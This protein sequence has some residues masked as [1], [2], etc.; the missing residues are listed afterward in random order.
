MTLPIPRPVSPVSEAVL[1]YGGHHQGHVRKDDQDYVLWWGLKDLDTSPLPDES[2]DPRAGSRFF[3]PARFFAVADGMGGL[4]E[5]ATA[6]RQAAHAALDTFRRL[7]LEFNAKAGEW[8]GG[9]GGDPGAVRDWADPSIPHLAGSQM[10]D[11]LQVVM[12]SVEA[13]NAP[14]WQESAGKSGCTLLVAAVCDYRVFIAYVGDCRAYLI[15]PQGPPELITQD[16]NLAWDK[17]MSGQMTRKESA[18]LASRLTRFVGMGPSLDPVGLVTPMGSGDRLLLCSDGLY[19]TIEDE[20]ELTRLAQRPSA[21]EAVHDLISSANHHGASDNVSALVIWT[22]SS[23]AV[24][25][26]SN[27]AATA[28]RPKSLIPAARLRQARSA[29]PWRDWVPKAGI[30]AAALVAAVM[31]VALINP[32]IGDKQPNSD[33]NVLS[34]SQKA[35]RPGE[36]AAA[37]GAPGSP[38]P[39][40]PAGCIHTN[41]VY[42]VKDGDTLDG[43]ARTCGTTR[44]QLLALNRG[45]TRPD[46]I[47]PGLVLALPTPPPPPT[48]IPTSPPPTPPRPSGLISTPTVVTVDSTQINA[49]AEGTPSQAAAT[50]ATS[51][52]TPTTANP[53]VLTSTPIPPLHTVTSTPTSPAMVTSTPTP[54]A[55]FTHTPTPDAAATAATSA[56]AVAAATATA[57]A[58][59]ATAVADKIGPASCFSPSGPPP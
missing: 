7:S 26:P 34:L 16:H 36:V 3:G 41:Y 6:A 29:V 8:M 21:E 37:F 57:Q 55:T 38:P 43:I 32:L 48:A 40:L 56:T 35:A 28:H 20:Q 59:C 45:V 52:V 42:H 14:V 54:A 33:Q 1:A 12:K 4:A 9:A 24:P 50:P 19:G 22:P 51:G 25:V 58:V 39:S 18:R 11:A 17:V 47:H 13:A 31:L 15:H 46:D 44:D 5:G 23:M 30:G 2:M 10:L 49:G 53:R 27:I